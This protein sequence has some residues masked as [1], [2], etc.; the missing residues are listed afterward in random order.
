[1]H[2]ALEIIK[3]EMK[4]REIR[5]N[6][7]GSNMNQK[8]GRVDHH[9]WWASQALASNAKVDSTHPEEVYDAR[10]PRRSVMLDSEYQRRE[11][12]EI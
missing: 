8:W 2:A 5:T 3:A 11:G 7:I 1:M 4:N 6:L 12:E 9:K 10:L